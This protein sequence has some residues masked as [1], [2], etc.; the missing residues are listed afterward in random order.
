L[1]LLDAAITFIP[2]GKFSLTGG[3]FKIPFS[4]ESLQSGKD[5]DLVERAWFLDRFRPPNGRDIGLKLTYLPAD[6]IAIEAG[7]YNGNGKAN[8]RDTND[9]KLWSGR[10][11]GSLRLGDFIIEPEAAAIFA[12]SED[13]C[14]APFETALRLANPGFSLY[15]KFEKHWGAAVFYGRSS[16]KYEYMQGRFSPQDPSIRSILA[17][18]MY[19]QL[20][21]HLA[22]NIEGFLRAENFDEDTRSTTS[23]DVEWITAGLLL[24]RYKNL[25]YKLNY[26]WR[27][28]AVNSV[29]DDRLAVE[30]V[31]TY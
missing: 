20:G 30:A 26:T 15:D 13:A 22:G 9:Q 5:I 8:T 31:V 17:D 11:S 3:Q 21:Y 23:G 6:S 24:H 10:I 16:L 28:E 14:D 12:P 19:L 1:T 25:R 2:S 7:V 18:G 27:N 4:R 29:D